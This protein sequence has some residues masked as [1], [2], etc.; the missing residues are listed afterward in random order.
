[1]LVPVYQPG[2]MTARMT[3]INDPAQLQEANPFVPLMQFNAGKQAAQLAHEMPGVR[4]G[5]VLRACE[6]RAFD[7]RVK[8]DALNLENWLMIGVECT[9]CFPAQ[10]FEWRA[11]NAGGVE[12]LTQLVLR[13]ARQGGI[14]L[15]RFRSACQICSRPEPSHFDLCL[16]LLGLPVR[17]TMLVSA[18]NEAITQEL[19]L[20][21]ITDGPASPELIAQHDHMVKTIEERRQRTREREIRNLSPE[22]PS[23][24]E[25]LVIF[26]LGCQ[27][28]QKCMEACPALVEEFI[29]TMNSDIVSLSLAKRWL[30]SCAECGMCEQ[31]CPKK[32]PLAAIMNR[33]SRALKSEPVAV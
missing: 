13:N 5:I 1:M 28:C 25:E 18:K 20:H 2:D 17:E 30:I 11:Q 31:G 27:P 6:L 32:V 33:I 19:H 29:P 3:L 21:E 7:E 26:L 4:L 15:D 23:T 8:R 16:E 10:D 12:G 14:A 9:A 22:L 24:L